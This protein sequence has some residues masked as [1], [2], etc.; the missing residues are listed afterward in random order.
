VV[1]HAGQTTPISIHVYEADTGK[2]GSSIKH[3]FDDLP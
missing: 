2:L 3:V 1:W